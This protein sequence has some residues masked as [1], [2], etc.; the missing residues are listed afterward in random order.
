MTPSNIMEFFLHV[1][2]MIVTE[3][4]IWKSREGLFYIS[5]RQGEF[6]PLTNCP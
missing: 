4:G 5:Y 3:Q 2:S 6:F 1:A